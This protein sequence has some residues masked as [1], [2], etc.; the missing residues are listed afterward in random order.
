[1]HRTGL[2]E[3]SLSR[4]WQQE[5][6]TAVHVERARLTQGSA[7]RERKIQASHFAQDFLTSLRCMDKRT[8]LK[9]TLISGC[10]NRPFQSEGFSAQFT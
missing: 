9:V 8:E 3:D 2:A 1:M 6:E 5:D 7:L 10:N 4:F